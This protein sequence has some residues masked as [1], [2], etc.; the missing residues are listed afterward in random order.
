[1][2]YLGCFWN[3]IYVPPLGAG[4]YHF[5]TDDNDD[6]VGYVNHVIPT[7]YYYPDTLRAA[8]VALIATDIA[9]IRMGLSA[10][11]HWTLDNN[12]GVN[13]RLNFSALW[14]RDFLGFY[15][16]STLTGANTYTGA[17]RQRGAWYP[18]RPI[19]RYDPQPL[20][21]G[22][23]EQ[24]FAASGA[25]ASEACGEEVLRTPFEFTAIDNVTDYV[26]PSGAT[27]AAYTAGGIGRNDYQHARDLWWR[28]KDDV[29]YATQGWRNGRPVRYY[30][31]RDNAVLAITGG[32]T[33]TTA[34]TY[35]TWVFD[36]ESLNDWG[37]V[38][39]PTRDRLSILYDLAWQ[40]RQ[41]VDATA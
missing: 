14:L 7:G 16:T 1:M 5:R 30:P 32:A 13:W 34:S 23:A 19:A 38:S 21:A 39:R 26:S 2:S 24:E 8:M 22:G 12:G 25:P 9:A 6:G 33:L 17:R 36:K 10:T 41:W 29:S 18:G 31:D 28:L 4:A 11:G 15:G 40:G 3:Q 35:T 37:N 20:A 27:G